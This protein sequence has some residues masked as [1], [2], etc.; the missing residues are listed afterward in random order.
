MLLRPRALWRTVRAAPIRKKLA[1]IGA[2][3]YVVLPA[4]LIPD[5]A[6]IV[7]WLDDL[8]VVSLAVAWLLSQVDGE[9]RGQSP[10]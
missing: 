6:P 7:G 5:V 3:A 4:D 2:L 8:G 1:L 10:P 9:S